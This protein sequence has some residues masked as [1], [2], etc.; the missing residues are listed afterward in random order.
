MV[1]GSWAILGLMLLSVGYVFAS[2]EGDVAVVVPAVV[3]LNCACIFLFALSLPTFEV[4]V[5][6][7]G[8]MFAG[9]VTIYGVMPLFQ[10][11]LRNGIY[12]SSSDS[13]LWVSQPTAAEVG[14]VGWAHVVFFVVFAAGYLLVRRG[15][16]FEVLAVAE[17]GKKQLLF[18]GIFLG[19]VM[20]LQ[21]GIEL[22]YDLSYS[23]YTESYLVGENL[24]QSV[25]QIYSHLPGI[26][27][28][29]K[30]LIFCGIFLRLPNPVRIVGLWLGVE[31]ALLLFKMGWRTYFM[32]SLGAA[33]LF[34]HAYVRR[35]SALALAGAGGVILSVFLLLGV[36]RN[37]SLEAVLAESGLWEQSNEMEA[38][39]ANS[40]DLMQQM[41]RNMINLPP[42]AQLSELTVFIP[43]QFLPF[44]KFDYSQWY[45]RMT[46]KKEGQTSAFGVISQSLAG[47][48]WWELVVRGLLTGLLFAGL[49]RYFSKHSGRW[50][51]TV[52]YAWLIVMSYHSF[53]ATSLQ[54]FAVFMLE[55]LPVFLVMHV[56]PRP[57]LGTRL[58]RLRG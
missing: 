7:I 35:V 8:S 34:F 27:F 21:F 26:A 43:Q 36:A 47:F 49:H 55:A 28:T 4:P 51:H 14:M 25:N 48:G 58:I 5:F 53:R 1:R 24:P 32:L 16:N 9:V 50:L 2:R 22:A 23:T 42:E 45:A 10:Y 30:L 3:L 31:F 40:L 12:G 41:S 46:F 20:V 33:I 15:N 54:P 19:G 18:A 52:A 38:V 44:Q 6:E 56:I 13:R 39:F 37:S 57:D 11:Q 17:V 29:L